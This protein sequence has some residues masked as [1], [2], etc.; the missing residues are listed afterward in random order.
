[1]PEDCGYNKVFQHKYCLHSNGVPGKLIDEMVK[2]CDHRFGWHFIAHENMNYNRPDW[3][4][5]QTAYISFED[6]VDLV[7]V[8]LSSNTI[9]L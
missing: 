6:Q 9:N 1:M 4:E 7:N 8:V 2:K 3:Y 5:N